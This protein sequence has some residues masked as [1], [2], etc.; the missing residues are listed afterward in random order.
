MQVCIG[1][2]EGDYFVKVELDV[3]PRVGDIV[4][5]RLR[6]TY[7]DDTVFT[8]EAIS[9]REKA[10]G[11]YVV[12]DVVHLVEDCASV[13]DRKIVSRQVVWVLVKPIEE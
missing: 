11:R 1:Y 5:Y 6:R 9:S 3:L 7:D 10:E 8:E 2:H 4:V 13:S 12:T